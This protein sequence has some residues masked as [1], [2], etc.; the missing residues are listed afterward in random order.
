MKKLSLT[1]VLPE[2]AF[3]ALRCARQ[4]PVARARLRREPG[5]SRLRGHRQIIT[6][7]ADEPD[8]PLAANAFQATRSLRETLRPSRLPHVTHWPR[9]WRERARIVETSPPPRS[10]P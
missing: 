2:P 6:K 8:A 4:R 7:L 9:M 3:A 10:E 1:G 5:R